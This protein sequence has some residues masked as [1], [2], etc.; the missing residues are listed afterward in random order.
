MDTHLPGFLSIEGMV[1][2]RHH[3]SR[4]SHVHP[5]FA[6]KNRGRGEKD[7]KKIKKEKEN[8]E[9]EKGEKNRERER[10]E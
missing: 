4:P 5:V 9:K 1:E 3:S 7:R 10:E 6:Y 8:R 2:G